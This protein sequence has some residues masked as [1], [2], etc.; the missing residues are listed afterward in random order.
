MFR[1]ILVPIDGSKHAHTALKMALELAEVHGSGL[2]ILHVTSYSEGYARTG[3]G[4]DEL[5]ED[6]AS[7]PEW[8]DEYMA[9]LRENDEKMLSQALTDAKKLHPE[10]D[11]TS[12][13]LLGRPG[14]SIVSEAEEDGFDLVVI[15]S[16]GL[17]SLAGLVLGSVSQHV[18]NESS[19]PVLV[20]K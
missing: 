11:I 9:K 4:A 12:K 13:L 8:I 10:L 18:V 16:R 1:K 15:G 6:S 14:R 3:S 5:S 2:E 17:G 7:P 19:T 20:V